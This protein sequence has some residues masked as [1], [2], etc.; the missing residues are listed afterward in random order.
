[1]HLYRQNLKKKEKSERYIHAINSDEDGSVII[2]TFRPKLLALIGEVNYF[3]GDGSFKRCKG[4]EEWQM[5]IYYTP[6]KRGTSSI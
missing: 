3:E 5:V 1:M 6:L 2:F 4:W